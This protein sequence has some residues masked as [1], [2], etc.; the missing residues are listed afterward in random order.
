MANVKNWQA[1]IIWFM[2]PASLWLRGLWG[3]SLIKD[4]LLPRRD[5]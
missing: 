1:F 5:L 2:Q 4:L 3:I